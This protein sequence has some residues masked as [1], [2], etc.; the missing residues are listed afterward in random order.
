M[1]LYLAAVST[2]LSKRDL[3][4]F[5]EKYSPTY[6]L[7]SFYY[8][9]DPLMDYRKS[10]KCKDFML[11]SGAF[12]F[13]NSVG[14]VDFEKYA[15][16]YADFINR[17]GVDKFFEIDIDAI[18]GL[19]YSEKLRGII[20]RETG[21]QSIPVF[22]RSRG[23]QYF[24]DMCKAYKYVALGGIAIKDIKRDEYKYFNWF[25]DTAHKYGCKIHGLGFTPPRDAKEYR[26]DSIDSSTWNAGARYGQLHVFD[27]KSIVTTP[28]A[29]GKRGRREPLKHQNFSAWVAYQNY[30]DGDNQ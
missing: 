10:G 30:L 20:E 23:K 4:Y 14:T 7:E 16:E 17:H 26:F 3:P 12:T 27:G 13:I 1:N 9:K 6:I 19:A 2:T 8:A 21:K 18:K 22:H 25:C 5:L 28:P 11:D 29:Q 24:V 15:Y